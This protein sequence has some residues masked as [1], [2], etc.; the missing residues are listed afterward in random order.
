MFS[1]CK[2]THPATGVEHAVTCYF[3]NRLE[4]SLVVAGANIIRVYR[5]MPEIDMNKRHMYTGM[6]L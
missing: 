1:L 4:K 3:F 6:K 5:F 2:L